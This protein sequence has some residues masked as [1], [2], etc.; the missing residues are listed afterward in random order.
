M[1]CKG[2]FIVVALMLFAAIPMYVGCASEASGETGMA[3]TA[4]DQPQPK[5]KPCGFCDAFWGKKCAEH[6]QAPAAPTCESAPQAKATCSQDLPPDAA[7]GEC[8]AKVFIPAEYKTETERDLVKEASERIEITPA[9]YKWVEERILVKE[10][11]TQLVEVPAEY[12]WVEKTVCVKPAHTGWVMEKKTRCEGDTKPRDVFCLVN[13]PAEYKTVRTQ[14]LVKPACTRE[15]IIPAEYNTVRRQVVAVPASTKRICI[16]A[17]YAEHE[18]TVLVAEACIKWEHIVCEQKVTADTVNKVKIALAAA[19]Y[20][21][22]PLDGQLAA[23][24]WSALTQFQKNNR[25]GVGEL[26]Y[27]TL[28]KLGVPTE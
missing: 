22:G 24:D 10:A 27:E 5:A 16:P 26:S 21:P 6:A 13:T 23:A 2:P 19:G 17:E 15:E 1:L 12:K 8:Y 20:V 3:R 9:E 11:S 14:V 18:R 28:T 7:E 25:I 4:C